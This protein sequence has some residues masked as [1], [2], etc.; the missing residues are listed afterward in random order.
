MQRH[1]C[2]FFILGASIATLLVVMALTVIFVLVGEEPSLWPLG[3]D[4]A[5]V[6]IRGPIWET[7]S[8]VR[9]LKKYSRAS[10]VGAIILRIDSGGGGV[11]ASQEIYAAVKRAARSGKPIV[12]SLGALG[13]SGAY[14]IACGADSIV[15]NPGTITGSIGVRMEFPIAE[16]LLRKIGVEFETIKSAEHKDIGSPYRQ[17]TDAERRLMKE[18]IDDVYDQFVN[19]I[20][21]ERGLSRE[22]VLRVA[23]GRVFSGRQARELGFVDRIGSLED[24]IDLAGAMAGVSGTPRVVKERRREFSLLDLLLGRTA[25]QVREQMSTCRLGYT[26]EAP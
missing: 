2:L 3:N 12:A 6:E 8:I 4:V 20:V 22:A 1:G 10:S 17:M 23:D 5:V 9:Q 21:E 16:E 14:Y 11:G 18:L 15:A 7:E 25:A 13:A 26:M 19:V 24:A